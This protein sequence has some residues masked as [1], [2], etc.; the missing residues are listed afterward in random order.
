MRVPSMTGRLTPATR[1]TAL[2]CVILAGTG[3]IASIALGWPPAEGQLSV[4]AMLPQLAAL[5]ALAAGMLSLFQTQAPATQANQAPVGESDAQQVSALQTMVW[6]LRGILAEEKVK[7]AT[8][9][10][11]CGAT[12]HDANVMSARMARLAEASVEAEQRLTAA[13]A[14][15]E[16]AVRQ[17]AAVVNWAAEAAQRI[18]R[19]LP[20]FAE[21]IRTS[22]AAQAE[23]LGP[24]LESAATRMVTDTG[25]TLNVFH[26][27]VAQAAGAINALGVRVGEVDGV[28]SQLPAAAATVTAAADQAA[29]S[30]ADAAAALRA[31]S[32]SLGATGQETINAAGA[33]RE[34]AETLRATGQEIAGVER[35]TIS[36]VAATIEAAAARLSAVIAD[37]D[38]ARQGSAS[39]IEL[40]TR[41]EAAAATLAE[42][43]NNLD[44]AGQRV[45]AKAEGVSDGLD[46][47]AGKIIAAAYQA[48]V[49]LTQA[50]TALSENGATLG[51]TLG[52]AGRETEQAAAAL[53]QEAEALRATGQEVADQEA[54]AIRHIT[55]TTEAAAAHLA[56][57]IADADAAR[58]GSVAMVDL[59]ARLE[60]AAGAL[61]DNGEALDATSRRIATVGEGVAD[62][63]QIAESALT[64]AA[65][66]LSANS[67][68]LEESR[69]ETARAATALQQDAAALRYAAQDIA[70]VEHSAITKVTETME[71]ATASLSAVIADADAA[72]K[73]SVAMVD[74]TARL[75]NAAATLAAGSTSLETAGQRLAA[76]ADAAAERLAAATAEVTTAAGQVPAHVAEASSVAMADFTARLEHAAAVLADGSASLDA[77][78]QRLAVTADDV[79]GRIGS[80]AGDVTAAASQVTA[81]LAEA[82]AVLCGDS[83]SLD[84]SG[85]ETLQAAVALRQSADALRAA[86]DD[87]FEAQRQTMDGAVGQW[88]ATLS[89]AVNHAAAAIGEST[90][91]LDH[92][93]AA[94]EGAGQRFAD[95]GDAIGGQL[96]ASLTRFDALPDIAA[97]MASSI[98]ALQVETSVLASIAN[99]VA[100]AGGAATQAVTDIAARVEVSTASLD[101]TGR[102][103]GSTADDIAAQIDRLAVASDRADS[104]AAA[105]PDACAR[106]THAAEV[107]RAW[108]DRLPAPDS[109]A[110][111]ATRFEAVLPRL[112][113][114]DTLS[115][116]LEETVT[117]LPV[118]D[119]Q[120]DALATLAGLTADITTA[121][122]R[123]EAALNDH[124]QAG[125]ALLETVA[126]VQAAAA[127]AANAATPLSLPDGVPVVL[128][129]TLRDLDGMASQSETILKQ[130]EA[131]AE[132][133]MKGLA[134]TL[135]SLL[136][137]RTPAILA[138]V[139]TTIKRLAS[140]ATALALASD[141]KPP[142]TPLIPAV[143]RS[144]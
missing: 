30:L 95:S 49:T 42:G 114:L 44:A 29:Q 132:A 64:E 76:T 36:S 23:T 8:F 123:V 117:A 21:I 37:A 139:E 16:K 25:T 75:E 121:I 18:E 86:A 54:G 52:A 66:V 119:Q 9:Q 71:S 135:P 116:R 15:A 109:L 73:G 62:R 126:R 24:A 59:A 34:E 39:M 68:G 111:T 144:A 33:L 20:E 40:A 70:G 94:L 67:A 79:A 113:L 69:R 143:R 120:A 83:A 1:P 6:E 84:A 110:S 108:A 133:V 91:R 7:L 78:G 115:Q 77:A 82:S 104:H 97:H 112:A 100:E 129:S 118:R 72:R 19:A 141:G 98:S 60:T 103:I 58:Q 22:I 101:T 38:A 12:A 51:A 50:S 88:S 4:T 13:T 47:A 45:A 138:G 48:A 89:D 92:T 43:T 41:L 27:S 3:L 63:L 96:A 105:L 130:T 32:A 28:L 53:R 81:N 56:A 35:D 90:V 61:A 107:L 14:A 10:E 142:A 65:A 46:S 106:I 5:F 102:L 99:Q 134:P 57:V 31:D 93:A 124:D 127:E 136:G 2:I 122:G 74:L 87:H 125:T 55:D 80:A 11:V 140:V 17:P 26:A 128:A 137:E 131:L 85:Q